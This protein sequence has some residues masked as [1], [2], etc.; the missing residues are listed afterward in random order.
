[1]ISL[2]FLALVIP[3]SALTPGVIDPSVTMEMV[4]QKGGY[5][6]K[7]GV[8][9]VSSSTKKQVFAEYHIDPKSDKFEIDHLISLE[10]GGKND[11]QNLWPQSY[12][13]K[14]YNAHLK[15]ALEDRLHAM[16]CHKQITIQEAQHEIVGDWTVAYRKYF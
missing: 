13:S 12:T 4:C 11:I 10:L 3:D 5:T 6:N 14:P 2:L 15:D 16:V 1:M 8:R 9:N 7:A